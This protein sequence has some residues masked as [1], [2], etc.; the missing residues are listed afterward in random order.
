MSES[1]HPRKTEK[2]V[3]VAR[4]GVA[5]YDRGWKYGAGT[6]EHDH[7]K[8]GKGGEVLNPEQIN[9]RYQLRNPS[10]NDIQSQ[11][12]GMS[13]RETLIS[14]GDISLNH[15]I[16]INKRINWIHF[17]DISLNGNNF[18]EIGTDDVRRD[19][20][21]VIVYGKIQGTSDFTINNGERVFRMQ[22]GGRWY[23]YA[24]EIDNVEIAWSFEPNS[25]GSEFHAIMANYLYVNTVDNCYGPCWNMASPDA[26]TWI[27]GNRLEAAGTIHSGDGGASI[28]ARNHAILNTARCGVANHS[29]LSDIDEDLYNEYGKTNAGASNYKGNIYILLDR[30][31]GY[32]LS[33]G[34]V[35]FS[36]SNY[37]TPPFAFNTLESVVYAGHKGWDSLQQAIDFAEAEGLSKVVLAANATYNEAISISAVSFNDRG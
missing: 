3:A 6:R 36:V 30:A 31:N 16:T 19:G 25:T 34:S 5:K 33:M 22:A 13:E 27:E 14:T 24:N 8:P 20:G 15:S 23:L 2:D 21:C 18:V 32:T 4:A 29:T 28:Y 11:I 26:V 35:V 37:D 12:D 1:W 17:G 9:N 10:V 7:S